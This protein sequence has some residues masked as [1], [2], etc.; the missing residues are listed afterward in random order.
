MINLYNVTIENNAAGN[1]V[2]R[3]PEDMRQEVASDLERRDESTVWA[4]IFE[5]YRCNGSFTPVSPES[6][7]FGLTD[8]PYMVAD[9]ATLEDD[10]SL[11][12][13]G[14]LYHF[15]AYQVRSAIQDLIDCGEVTLP[16]WHTAPASGER[17][18][19]VA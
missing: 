8:D 12:V 3:L 7:Y 1:L 14:G 2:I 10:G 6:H 19:S 13:Y 11:T 17:R 9:D 4:D 15:P 5:S 16:R 18:E